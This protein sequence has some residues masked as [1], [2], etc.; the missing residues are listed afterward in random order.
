[1]DEVKTAEDA[2]LAVAT[3]FLHNKDIYPLVIGG[4]AVR[5]NPE[6]RKH[7]HELVVRFTAN[8]ES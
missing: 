7:N 2:L 3:L 1:M 6:E 8:M 4:I 5:H